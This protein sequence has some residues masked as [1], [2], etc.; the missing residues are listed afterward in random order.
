MQYGSAHGQYGSLTTPPRDVYERWRW[1]D[2][3]R[4]F[5][6]PG[7]L[8][9][10]LPG[11]TAAKLYSLAHGQVWAAEQGT[12]S[13][14]MANVIQRQGV[15]A[16]LPGAPQVMRTAPGNDT[17]ATLRKA[18]WLATGARVLLAANNTDG[19]NQL[20]RQASFAYASAQ[21]ARTQMISTLPI[22]GDSG[23][24]ASAIMQDTSAKLRLWGLTAMADALVPLATPEAVVARQQKTSGQG[25]GS[26][27][28]PQ[29][30]DLPAKFIEAIPDVVP[31][32]LRRGIL[33]A[34]LGGLAV[35][36]L[37]ST[38]GVVGLVVYMKY[39]K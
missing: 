14:G 3:G 25:A 33:G 29:A 31:D 26:L 8:G 18:W 37:L 28:P 6:A 24:N 11:G 4:Q 1:R 20:K 19:W 27:I 13:P 32:V 23:R 5:S 38:V 10:I 35:P 2:G 7:A 21:P 22:V 15:G 12:P 34:A 39:R 9:F 16:A 36:I 17:G 30:K